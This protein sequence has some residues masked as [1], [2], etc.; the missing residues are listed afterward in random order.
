VDPATGRGR[1]LGPLLEPRTDFQANAFPDGRVLVTGGSLTA[2]TSEWFDP[3]TNRFTPGPAL[4]RARQ[5][6]RALLLKDGRLVLV[7][8]TEAPTPAEVLEPGAAAFKPIA[9]AKF[10]LCAEAVE[11]DEGR[12]LL[13]DGASG[14]LSTWDGKRAPSFK[15]TLNRP[16]NFFRAVR[17][18]DGRVAIT[19]GWP[20]EQKVRGRKPATGPSLPVECFNP[21][22]STLSTWSQV[23]VPRA[24]HQ[25]TLLEDGRLCLWGGV[26]QDPDALVPEVEVLDPAKETV[27]RAGTVDLGG[28]PSPAWAVA[29]GGKG[30]YLPERSQRLLA[31]AD[32]LALASAAPAGRLANGYLGPTLVPLPDGSV[33]VLGTAAFG[34]PLDRWDARTRQC[35]VVGTLRLGVQSLD[36]LPDGRVI[37]LGP[38]VDVVDPRSGAMTPLGW[39]EDLEPLL[40]T[41]KPAPPVPGAPPFPKGQERT[42]AVVVGLDKTRALVVGGVAEGQPSGA[43][44]LWDFKKKALAPSGPMKT[45]RARPGGLKLNDG[46]VL[47]W[48]QG[49]E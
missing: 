36:Q 9:D 32:P 48:G 34:D 22:W 42:G 13:V 6:H 40:R 4:T 16:R 35:T 29:K 37:A 43:V 15:G 41:L 1:A 20:S 28:N 8:G 23:P 46:S 24:R 45:R 47:V 44:D 3:A 26:G 12:V 14:A 18:K 39:R 38:V 31:C 19:G 17:L 7:G 25:A 33:L 21:R 5:G 10:G 27:T 49:K 2:P 11:L 30:L